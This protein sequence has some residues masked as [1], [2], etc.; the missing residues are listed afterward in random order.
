MNMTVGTPQTFTSI[1]SGGAQPY[2]YQWYLNGSPV[3]NANSSN[4][5]FTPTASGNFTVYLTVRDNNNQYA[6]SNNALVTIESTSVITA[7]NVVSGG[8]GY[9][10]PVVILTGGGGTGATATA[11]VSNGVIFGIV[12]TNPGSGYSSAP[13]VSLRDPSPRAKGATATAV[14][15]TL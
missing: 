7:F 3:L 10:T 6:L 5:T 15:A 4:W 2:T 11:R 9:T 12:L 14:L 13:S 8:S 1:V